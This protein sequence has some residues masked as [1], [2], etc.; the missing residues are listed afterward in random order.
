MMTKGQADQTLRALRAEF[1]Q[2]A[3]GVDWYWSPVRN[4]WI[5]VTTDGVNYELRAVAGATCPCSGGRAA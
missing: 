3:D 5:G 2:S 1:R 4:Q